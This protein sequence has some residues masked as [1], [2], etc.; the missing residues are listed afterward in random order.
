MENPKTPETQEAQTLDVKSLEEA[1][2]LFGFC[3]N[4]TGFE[5]DLQLLVESSDQGVDTISQNVVG[6][7][8]EAVK[9]VVYSEGKISE[10]GADVIV[11][12]AEET[13]DT[14]VQS[15]EDVLDGE[16]VNQTGS[17]EAQGDGNL[18]DLS[19]VVVEEVG[20]RENVRDGGMKDVILG[21][22]GVDSV[23]KIDVSGDSISLYVDF[24]GSF[25]GFNE[26]T[27][28]KTRYL[29][30]TMRNE[31][32]T[33]AQD[34]EKEENQEF[35]FSLGDIV[36]VKT[37]SGTWWPGKILDPADASKYSL[38]SNHKQC[39]LA[40]YF[41]NSH[42]IWC[43]PSQL[44]PL[45]ENFEQMS[46]QNKAWSFLGAV[47]KALNEFGELVKS[48][49]SCSCI[50]KRGGMF[51][52]NAQVQERV[53]VPGSKYGKLD[54][55]SLAQFEPEK[56]LSQL[57]YLAKVVSTPSMLQLASAK[58]RLSSFYRFIGHSQLPMQQLQGIPPDGDVGAGDVLMAR[59]NTSVKV[60]D[61]NTK[62]HDGSSLFRT[63]KKKDFQVQ[64]EDLNVTTLASLSKEEEIF[65]SGSPNVG[66]VD[67]GD[68]EKSDRG[69][70]LRERK[71]SK[72][73]S[74]PYV[75][76]EHKSFPDETEDS[77]A[78]L[79]HFE[80]AGMNSVDGQFSGPPSVSKGSGKRFRKRWFKKFVSET[81]LP[82]NPEF[83]NA[84]SAKLL[85]ELR[86]TAVDC[87]YP[88]EIKNFEVTEWF[89]SRYRISRYHD[90]SIY[91]MYCKNIIRQTEATASEPCLLDR[92]SQE[93]KQ[94]SPGAKS[95]PK[96]RKGR[97]S[98]H[99]ENGVLTDPPV[100]LGSKAEPGLNGKH[101]VLP[102]IKPENKKNRGE[103]SMRSKVRSL[104]GLSDVNINVT[105]SS[106]SSKDIQEMGLQTKDT[107]EIPDLNANGTTPSLSTDVSQ[108]IT[109]AASEGKPV[110]KKRKRKG[111]VALQ[112]TKD[113]ICAALPNE[114]SNNV[115]PIPLLV[116]LQV[117]GPYSIHDIPM[118]EGTGTD[119]PDSNG[120]GAT[121]G[122]VVK[123]SLEVGSFPG[124]GN[125]E[126]K[127]RRRRRK[128]TFDLP[129]SVLP[130]GIPDLNGTSAE[131]I[132]LGKDLQETICHSEQKK[133]RRNRE[134]STGR[135]RKREAIGIPNMITD[136]IVGSNGEALETTLLLTFASGVSIPSKEVLI[137]TFCKFG[138]LKES[139]T[140]LLEDSGKAQVVFARRADAEKAIQ[141]FNNSNPFGATLLSFQLHPLSTD[142]LSLEGSGTAAKP[143][144]PMLHPKETL[145]IDA[146]RQN[147]EMMT[148]MLEKPGNNISPE[149]RTKLE[150]EI[151]GLLEK[152]RNMPCFSAS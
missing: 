120:N 24:S 11:G 36:W 113:E 31:V 110:R 100:V 87:L 70:D 127:K 79:V 14:V 42:V 19:G 2:G 84:T 96:K 144:G 54:E 85:S 133:R 26:E 145:P 66:N 72:Y 141:S 21:L 125:H 111:E 73:L 131:S 10:E 78:Q 105:T 59:D 5:S 38:K 103:N 90:E 80:G 89:F 60:R 74:Y 69:F 151:R 37:K 77:K 146:I 52:G 18:V 128:A 1:S 86:F 8:V 30:L 68:D 40:G 15:E 148:S 41:G 32:S 122:L 20:D 139:E 43:Y 71:K 95:D 34:D 62:P 6:L 91:E 136:H 107:K 115:D 48:E 75:N 3:E 49:M 25:T 147:L 106:L 137:A 118:Q 47:E 83:I 76:W 12:I 93:I 138:F 27:K 104:S 55:F 130:A 124:E 132:S 97:T 16:T 150:S 112:C 17:V 129:S 29:G 64:E 108:P 126:Q 39:L 119:L 152:V 46:R 4:F 99:S 135:P 121:K 7:E 50:L 33:K 140:K 58:G 94:I 61:H 9:A 57:K 53:F 35:K 123:D 23:K 88:N 98:K 45:H 28:E 101:V 44:K 143:S 142:S 82:V 65:S 51:D 56:F 67:A 149:M 109:H 116:D 81:T 134:G 63:Q 22:G 92:Q 102:S 117:T 114:I 13:S